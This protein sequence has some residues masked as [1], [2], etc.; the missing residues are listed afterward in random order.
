MGDEKKKLYII[1][2]V[3]F[4]CFSVCV[5][6]IKNYNFLDIEAE[7]AAA[8]LGIKSFQDYLSPKLNANLFLET[9]PVYY[10]ILNFFA[11]IFGGISE[12]S[13][14]ISSVIS[15]FFTAFST[16]FF[17]KYLTNKQLALITAIVT[18]TS[19]G[20]LFFS[21]ITSPQMIS[22]C[23]A[24]MAILSAFV[25]VF[26]EN[27]KYEKYYCLSFWICLT[28]SAFT[29]NITSVIFVLLLVWLI[30]F[31]FKKSK[32]VFSFKNTFAGFLLF[33]I[34]LTV[35]AFLSFKI[36][37]ELFLN[38][39]TNMLIPEY[40]I[41]NSIKEYMD[42]LKNTVQ[43]FVFGLMPWIFTFVPI[44]LYSLRGF[45]LNVKKLVSDGIQPE[46][47]N[48]LKLYY[49]LVT[50]SIITTVFYLL[51]GNLNYNILIIIL[52][53]TA[54]IAGYY[55]YNTI[56]LNRYFK[57]VPVCSSVFYVVLLICSISVILLY[58]F[59]T[60]IQ[61][62]NLT[63]FVVPV[64][65]L[66]LIVAI[67]GMLAVAM[68]RKILNFSMQVLFS[69]FMFFLSTCLLYDFIVQKGDKDLMELS[70]IAKENKAVLATYDIKNKYFMTYYYSAPVD[71]NEAIT[72]DKIFQK[73]GKSRNV[74]IV[75]RLTDLDYFDKFFVYEVV[76]TGKKYC[77]ITNI[78]YHR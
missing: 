33:I 20:F 63:P 40:V 59:G 39:V 61:K 64:S 75:A 57:A 9:A 51:S 52:Y 42:F 5:L 50:G 23:F 28:L 11:F 49:T 21:T 58:L 22:A 29:Y 76:E 47:S 31:I 54:S 44:F 55:W 4:L 30:T 69:V 25:P 73:Y 26:K 15:A 62:T 46:Q 70:K 78:K 1:G 6:C 53:F 14:R 24:I 17:I 68:N 8:S 41:S 60:T 72:A 65:M 7:Y 37:K 71:F 10:A 43:I 32:V 16:Y 67:P 66:T 74:F 56:C 2:A 34:S 12:L 77:M 3:T 19:L 13:I 36:N 38:E 18:S 45:F 27:L 35:W 48:E